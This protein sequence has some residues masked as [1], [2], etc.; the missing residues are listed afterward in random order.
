MAKP[1]ALVVWIVWMVMLASAW[2]VPA[3]GQTAAKRLECRTGEYVVGL[4]ARTGAWI[5]AIAPICARWDDRS[6][7]VAS[8][9]TMQF[10]GGPGGGSQQQ[11]CPAGSAVATWRVE[12]ILSGY[13]GF[14]EAVSMQCRMLAPPH[15]PTLPNVRLA[16]AGGLPA[17]AQPPQQQSCAPG[18]LV[19]AIDVWV[20]LDERF[21][22]DLRMQCESGPFVA[23]QMTAQNG[24]NG[25]V[26]YSSPSL[27]LPGGDGVRLDWCLEWANNCG[28]PAAD[29]F[30][31]SKG[32]AKAINF[33]QKPNAGL[34]VVISNKK[35]C[36]APACAAF[37]SI[38]CGG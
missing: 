7:Q 6:F 8:P 29:A 37:A 34:T 22:E 19:T 30:C 1:S 16:G 32:K 23:S 26:T 2:P 20:T 18:K 31:K 24:P 3:S 14:A 12:Q 25:T 9:R 17:V 36:N 13:H 4:A 10:A 28:Q 38:T 21:V 15:D 5:D 11:S 33:T 35:I 27:K